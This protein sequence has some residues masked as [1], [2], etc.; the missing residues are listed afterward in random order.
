MKRTP[1]AEWPCSIA[2]SVDLL[3]DWWTPLVLREA[4][5]GTRRFDDI[6]RNLRIGRNILT[7]RLKR[8]VEEGMLERVPY[9]ERPK[10]YEYVLTEK[11]RD[12]FPVLAAMMR[13]GDK[14]LSP[15]ARRS[16]CCTTATTPMPRSSAPSAGSPSNSAPCPPRSAPVSPSTCA[17]APTSPAA[18]RTTR[19][20]TESGDGQARG[21][22]RC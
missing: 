4:F 11:G 19:P 10:R 1:F 16:T 3:G 14:W 17:P 8:L 22:L 2:R 13:W 5:Y 7:Q 21:V 18:S 15:T 12:F 6:Q 20:W 9:Q